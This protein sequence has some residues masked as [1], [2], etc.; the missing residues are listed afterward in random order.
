MTLHP[1]RQEGERVDGGLVGPVHVLDDEHGGR[2]VRAPPAARRGPRRV[3]PRPVPSRRSGRA[4]RGQVVEGTQRPRG[5][6]GCRTRP[7]G[8]GP[9]VP[10]S[11]GQERLDQGGLADPRLAA[12]QDQPPGARR[13]VVEGVP[14]PARSASRSSSSRR[15][16]DP[17]MR[18]NLARGRRRHIGVRAPIYRAALPTKRRIRPSGSGPP[19]R[20][21]S[22]WSRPASAARRT[23]GGRPCAPTARAAPR[24]LRSS[25]PPRAAG[26]S[27]AGGR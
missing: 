4:A 25:G 1:A 23:R 3:P 16:P 20:R 14:Q 12:D 19:R 2:R 15:A 27:P 8:P 9:T 10:C 22:G 6:A 7:R 18:T 24:S 11:L 5:D 26:G 13:R 17:L 21:P